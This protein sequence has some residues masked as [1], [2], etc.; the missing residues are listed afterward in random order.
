MR[1]AIT[2]AGGQIGSFLAFSLAQRD[3]ALD[4]VA[5]CRN[6]VAAGL[7]ESA[8]C[9]VRVGSLTE[10]GSAQLLLGDCDAVVHCAYAA[11]LPGH[12]WAVNKAMLTRLFAIPRINRVIYLSSVAVYG[13]CIVNE[14][15]SFEKPHADTGY[16][17]AKWRS[18]LLAIRLARRTR[19]RLIV[20]RLGHV[21]GS[22]QAMSQFIVTKAR[23]TQF[24][25]PFDGAMPSNAIHIHRLTNAVKVSLATESAGAWNVTDQPQQTWRQLFDWHTETLGLPRVPAMPDTLSREAKR[26]YLARGNG[27][28][29]WHALR[30]AVTVA[31]ATGRTAVARSL[32]RLR[33]F[34]YRMLERLPSTLESKAGAVYWSALAR[35]AIVAATPASGVDQVEPWLLSDAMPGPYLAIGG[36]VDAWEAGE[37]SQRAELMHW[38]ARLNSPQGAWL[39][40]ERL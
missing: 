23:T 32:P 5:V 22:S 29:P 7:L 25:L 17:R 10:P 31:Q 18:E 19:R 34:G 13:K 15:G 1:V 33:E 4:V 3:Q 6:V 39:A 11:G 20:W 28:V 9:S 36:D 35:E 26:R 12:A 38:F 30:R 40:A 37:V 21:Y 2:G 16:G 24:S 14:V 8:P 27:L